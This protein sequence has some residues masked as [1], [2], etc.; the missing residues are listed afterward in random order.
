MFDDYA[1]YVINEFYV[2]S[3]HKRRIVIHSC[4]F[5]PVI[6]KESFSSQRH[7]MLHKTEL[8]CRI[9]INLYDLFWLGMFHE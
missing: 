9:S 6:M 1:S 4:L 3:F 5:Q 2:A 7:A 8:L